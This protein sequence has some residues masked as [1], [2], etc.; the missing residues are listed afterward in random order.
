MVQDV[1][2]HKIKVITKKSMNAKQKCFLDQVEDKILQTLSWDSQASQSEAPQL[3]AAG[4]HLCLAPGAKRARPF[5]QA[6]NSD[7][8]LLMDV[9]VTVEF[10]HGA[11]LLHDDVIDSAILRR[12]RVTVNT[13]WNNLTAVLAGDLLFAEAIKGLHNCPGPV[14]QEALELV[15]DMTRSTMTESEVRGSTEVSEALWKFIVKVVA[16]LG[17]MLSQ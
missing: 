17:L 10:I 6:L 5:G 15:A 16:V 7:D 11:S 9:A 12:G 14:A 1:L 2:N 3:V 8:S 13:R 4:Q